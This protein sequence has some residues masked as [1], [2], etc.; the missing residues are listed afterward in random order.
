MDLLLFTLQFYN[1]L[2]F[3]SFS[4]SFLF[5]ILMPCAPVLA[6]FSGKS[7]TDVSVIC[8]KFCAV[9]VHMHNICL[10]HPDDSINRKLCASI[11]LICVEV[12]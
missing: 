12:L 4:F 10:T 8:F 5:C 2:S 9:N 11:K 3:L 7:L 1:G 6:A